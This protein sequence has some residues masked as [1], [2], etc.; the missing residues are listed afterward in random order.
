MTPEDQKKADE[1]TIAAFQ[2]TIAILKASSAPYNVV[3]QLIPF[4]TELMER[5]KKA[6]NNESTDS[7]NS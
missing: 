1:N 7:S 5:V 6:Q 2:A 3:T 4:H